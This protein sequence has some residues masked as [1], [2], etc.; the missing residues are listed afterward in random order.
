MAANPT[1]KKKR[2]GQALEKDDNGSL[3]HTTED[4]N[5]SAR[6]TMVATAARLRSCSRIQRWLLRA[7]ERLQ[8]KILMDVANDFG[9]FWRVF[10]VQMI[11]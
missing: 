8:Q 4:F 3:I 2:K 11:L 1:K 9:C 10:D 5:R 7:V 6:V